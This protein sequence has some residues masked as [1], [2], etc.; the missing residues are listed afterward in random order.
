MM[1]VVVELEVE[2]VKTIVVVELPAEDESGLE[3]EVALVL[4]QP[5]QL[6]LAKAVD[7]QAMGVV[8]FDVTSRAAVEEVAVD[9]EVLAAVVV[10]VALLVVVV[11]VVLAAVVVVVVVR[12]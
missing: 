11:V 6:A 10:E 8:E 1:L 4:L 9:V 3:V 7:N 12:L 2:L 5:T